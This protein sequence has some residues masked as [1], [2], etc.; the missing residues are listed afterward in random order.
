MISIVCFMLPRPPTSTRTATLFPYPTLFRSH[1][2]A[3]DHHAHVGTA[4]ALRQLDGQIMVGVAV[5]IVGDGAGEFALILPIAHLAQR[6]HRPDDR[7]VGE[8][9]A[10]ARR[11]FHRALPGRGSG[12]RSEG[13]WV[14]I[15]GVSTC[16]SRRSPYH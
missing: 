4:D 2:A 1:G 12:D 3:A 6:L 7:S 8:G 14:G 16:S 5:G 13:R 10:F 9:G 11:D 15:G